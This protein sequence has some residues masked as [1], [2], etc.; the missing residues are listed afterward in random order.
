MVVEK[1]IV[2]PSVPHKLKPRLRR[3]ADTN[4]ISENDTNN[5]VATPSDFRISTQ[6]ADKISDADDASNVSNKDVKISE[7]AV[8]AHLK[9]GC[10]NHKVIQYMS[11]NKSLKNIPSIV[12]KLF[13]VGSA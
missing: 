1:D 9:F 10:R 5:D 3:E 12:I 8:I 13:V 11:T 6:Q 2:L 4:V 7:A